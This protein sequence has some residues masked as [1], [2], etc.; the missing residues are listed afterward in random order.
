M[1]NSKQINDYLKDPSRMPDPKES[2]KDK[3]D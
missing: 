3:L 2:L 1:G